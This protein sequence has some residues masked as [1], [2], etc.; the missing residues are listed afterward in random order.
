MHKV[1]T[2]VDTYRVKGVNTYRVKGVDTYR[3]KGVNTNF[4]LE[5]GGQKDILK[6]SIIHMLYGTKNLS[7]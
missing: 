6:S 2:L 4:V 7:E 3:V 5:G 1:D